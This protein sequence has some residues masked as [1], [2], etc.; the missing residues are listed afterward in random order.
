MGSFFPGGT[1][2]ESVSETDILVL[3]A[4]TQFRK[5]SSGNGK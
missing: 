5:E 1:L 4:G 3:G 2:S